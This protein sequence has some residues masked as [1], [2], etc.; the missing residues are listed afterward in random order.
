M[1]KLVLR[2]V[3]ARARSLTLSI[4]T[5][6]LGAG[7][8]VAALSLQ[9]SADRVAAEG[10]GAFWGLSEAP[11]V[12]VSE[13]GDG[14]L[15]MTPSGEPTRLDPAVMELLAEFPGVDDLLSEA[16]FPAYVVTDELTLGDQTD[17]SWGHSWALADAEPLTMLQ[18]RPPETV[19]EVVLDSRTASDAAL[20]PGDRT[21]V[22]TADGTLT[23][24]VTGIVD[25]GGDGARGIFFSPHEAALRGGDP[26]LAVIRPE[27]G[28][29]LSRL[30]ETIREEVPEVEV[31]TGA[32]RSEALVLDRADRELASGMGT[33]LGTVSG[34]ASVVAA[35]MV[36]GLLTTAVRHRSHEFALLRLVGATP[37]LIRRL[38]VG[39]ALVL[40]C[41]AALLS[42][43]VGALSTR[44]LAWFFGLMGVLP[45]GFEPSVGWPALA[46]GAALALTVP[47][48]ASWRPA[49]SAG[50]TAPVEAMRTVR[51]GSS[52]PSR[53][54]TAL[55]TVALVGAAFLFLT[56]WAF[57]G[58]QGAVVAALTAAMVF[59]LA[60]ALL[61][62]VLAGLL[63]RPGRARATRGVVPFL[64]R[65]DAYADVR[66]VAGVMTP[67]LLTTAVACLLLF[68]GPT[69]GQ[70]R[71][72]SYGERLAA[73]LVV[74]GAV[75]V[76]LPGDT[77]ERAA[78][79]PGVAAAGGFRQ[80][81]TA[82]SGPALTTHLV[83]PVSVSEVYRLDVEQGTWKTFDADGV[84]LHVDIAR[85]EGWRVGDTITLSGPDGEPV[86][87]RVAVL[88][89]AG[90]DFPEVLLP[91]Q[92]MAPRMLDAMESAVY[93]T[94]DP[95]ADPVEVARLLEEAIDAGPELLVT[96]RAEHL[97]LLTAQSE[98]DDWIIHLMVVL[99]A[100]FAGIGAINTLVLSVTARTRNFALLRLAGAS[101]GQVVGM[102]A[103]EATM[104]SVV[105]VALGSVT[106][107]A[108]LAATGYAFTGDT[109]VLSVSAGQYALVASLI[110]ALGTAAS[111]APA[112]AA[113]RAR[114]LHVVSASS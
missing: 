80:T 100:G 39:E 36:A 98:G 41:V 24:L 27:E 18:G 108:G 54:R 66:R 32:D 77:V 11:I 25:A 9:G 62:P 91:R 111:L 14:G 35:V 78:D 20:A 42:W 44:L 10:T 87:A 4:L 47:L 22:L 15:T 88:Y 69:T 57:S 63:L 33:F 90:L 12:V 23:G 71:T 19:G 94:L 105:A 5:V 83:D 109:V 106:A 70:A 28:T 73:D 95:H 103:L 8:A 49:R 37:G 7:L 34:L 17:R 89:D 79:V 1:I 58:T 102:V 40:G 97:E 96:D 65:K 92:S 84:A 85:D 6:A 52:R 31:L 64:T 110:L 82:A 26:V 67:L 56:A 61:T 74:S 75:G 101:R 46:A 81:V 107:L 43:V 45:Q 48:L 55:G 13:P 21:E 93:V 59:I 50:R 51:A 72:H 104:V 60:A 38:V 3:A 29:N 30:A 112:V 114:P 113:L 68:Q 53:A 76:G 16:P 86:R 2:G 99:V